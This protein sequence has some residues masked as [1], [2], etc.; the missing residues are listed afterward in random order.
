MMQLDQFEKQ[1]ILVVEDDVEMQTALSR[2]LGSQ[3][4]PVMIANDGYEGMDRLEREGA[5]LVLADV[6]LPRKDGLEMLREI[7]S[8][9]N[10]VPVVMMTA[11]GSVDTA[12]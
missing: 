10:Q 6:S 8:G 4:Y 3:G 9:G 1:P 11:Y 7:R 12:I 2:I 5:W